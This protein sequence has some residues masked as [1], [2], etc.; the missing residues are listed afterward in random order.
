MSYAAMKVQNSFLS[1]RQNPVSP[2]F[3]IKFMNHKYLHPQKAPM[4]LCKQVIFSILVCLLFASK[5]SAQHPVLFETFTNICY[6]CPDP[7]RQTFD[8][9]VKSLVQ[10]KG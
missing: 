9:S 1:Q 8:E 10:S 6:P 3:P 5:A 2:Y 4:S 7:T